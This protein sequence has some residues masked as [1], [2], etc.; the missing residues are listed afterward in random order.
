MTDDV[1]PNFL[2]YCR[3]FIGFIGFKKSPGAATAT[4]TDASAEVKAAVKSAKNAQARAERL[5]R[6]ELLIKVVRDSMNRVGVLSSGYKFKTLSTDPYGRS[7]ILMVDGSFKNFIDSGALQKIEQII[8]DASKALHG[9]HVEAIYWRVNEK[10]LIKKVKPPESDRD[11]DP[12]SESEIEKFRRAL[13]RGG[14]GQ[15]VF[16]EN[17][18]IRKRTDD[19]V[20]GSSVYGDLN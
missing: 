4:A 13:S 16:P 18:P 7:Y 1:S 10:V 14:T 15:D 20:L 19:G 3:K 12:V 2:S 9:I 17:K 6:Q 11:S 8:S 5:S